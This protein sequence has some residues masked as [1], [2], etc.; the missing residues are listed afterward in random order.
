MKIHEESFI[1]WNP[2]LIGSEEAIALAAY[3]ASATG[4]VTALTTATQ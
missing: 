3:A 2:V 4:G 1:A